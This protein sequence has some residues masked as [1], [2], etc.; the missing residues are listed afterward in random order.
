MNRFHLV[1]AATLA[2]GACA[3][4]S[5][6]TDVPAILRPPANESLALVLAATGVQ[7][8]ECRAGADGAHAWAFVAPEAELFDRWGRRIGHH[9]AGPRW[10]FADGSGVIG[11]VQQRAD[12]PAADAIPWLLLSAKAEGP[13]GTA[14]GISSIQRIHTVGGVAPKTGCSAQTAGAS[15]RIPY[16]A[17]YTF[18]RRPA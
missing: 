12:A 2:L 18:Y 4:P 6:P 17:D 5:V 10:H 7:I 11:S 15:A 13:A 3:T 9:D 16:T 14:T 1:A 8:Y